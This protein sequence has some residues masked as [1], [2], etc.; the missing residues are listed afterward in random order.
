MRIRCVL[1][2]SAQGLRLSFAASDDNDLDASGRDRGIGANSPA[3]ALTAAILLASLIWICAPPLAAW[4]NVNRAG[5]LRT[6]EI[7]RVLAS[8][9][10][11]APD[12]RWLVVAVHHHPAFPTAIYTPTKY[13]SR[14]NSQWFLSAVAQIRGGQKT[15]PQAAAIERHAREFI[16]HDLRAHPDPVLIDTNSARHT[17]ASPDFDFLTFFQEDPAFRSEWRS[18]REIEP[19]GAY[20]QFLRVPNTRPSPDRRNS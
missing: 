4:W 20:R 17:S 18:Y 15:P 7:D 10:R 13:V 3:A 19:I 16:L 1:P 11:H 2:H 14:T 6:M 12:G 9:A 8:L 5:G